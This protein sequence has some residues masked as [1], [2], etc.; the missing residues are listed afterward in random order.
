MSLD[1][2]I[3]QLVAEAPPDGQTPQIVKAIAPALKYF[4]GKL[5]HQ[6]YYIL[7]N[8]DE[9]WVV[10]TLSNR[11]QPEKQKRVIYAFPSV[12]DA[13]QNL[14]TSPTSQAVAIS[15]P[16][17]HI[18]FQLLALKTIDSLIFFE[19]PGNLSSGVEVGQEDFQ[20]LI[21]V[22]LKHA[23]GQQPPRNMA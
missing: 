11:A 9:R 1:Q 14:T 13:T 23:F 6:H 21:Q 20:N 16:V 17:T 15:M 5:Q 12:K 10:H 7:Q 2:Q 22:Q 8:L 4:A 18:L 3:E 19:T